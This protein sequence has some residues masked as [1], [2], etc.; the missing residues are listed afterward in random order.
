MRSRVPLASDGFVRKY[1]ASE[2]Q[3]G[4]RLGCVRERSLIL[5]LTY[6]LSFLILL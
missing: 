5:N 1:T 4:R 6:N 3:N 2:N